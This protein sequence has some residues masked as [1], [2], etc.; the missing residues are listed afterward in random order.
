MTQITGQ[1]EFWLVRFKIWAS[2]KSRTITFSIDVKGDRVIFYFS[3]N[4]LTE[5]NGGKEKSFLMKV[6]VTNF[7][8]SFHFKYFISSFCAKFFG[9]RPFFIC[10]RFS[11]KEVLIK[12]QRKKTNL[13]G[14]LA[15][16]NRDVFTMKPN[17]NFE[18][19]R[20]QSIL[21]WSPICSEVLLSQQHCE[22]L[23]SSEPP[24]L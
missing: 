10:G 13:N 18:Q 7:L 1:V 17:L 4:L 6:W 15:P 14:K 22:L 5:R 16:R 12:K 3:A 9:R 20:S 2:S 23:A 19:V 24:S 8:D 11:R 21:W